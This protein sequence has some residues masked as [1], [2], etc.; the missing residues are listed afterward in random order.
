MKKRISFLSL[1]IITIYL[2]CSTRGQF[3]DY[4]SIHVTGAHY[5]GLTKIGD[6]NETAAV[7]NTGVIHTYSNPEPQMI[8]GTATQTSVIDLGPGTPLPVLYRAESFKEN[9]RRIIIGGDQ[10]LYEIDTTVGSEAII[11][12]FTDFIGRVLRIVPLHGTNF[13][14]IGGSIK[15]VY[16]F[17]RTIAAS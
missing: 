13:F 15:I 8:A 17:D 11:M 4:Y 2:L 6:S 16:K 9:T 12:T 5:E 3:L 7:G 1:P 10:V 14:V